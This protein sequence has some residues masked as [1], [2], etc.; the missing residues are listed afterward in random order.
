M[1]YCKP[2][3]L[4]GILESLNETCDILEDLFQWSR[5]REGHGSHTY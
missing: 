3:L 2:W 4:T 5:M 1:L